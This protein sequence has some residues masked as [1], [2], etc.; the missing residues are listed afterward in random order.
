L[1]RIAPPNPE[2]LVIPA[3]LPPDEAERLAAL[4][5]YQVLDTEPEAG[6]DDL[7]A[8]AAEVAATPIALVS[9]I[10]TDR[11]WFKSRLGLAAC[12]TGRD[13]AFCSHA[14]L[15]DAPM[16]VPETHADARF[17]D[18]P[19]VT[20]EPHIRAYAGIPLRVPA[21]RRVGTLCV[22]DTRPRAF[23]PQQ[24]AS[25]QRLARQVV[26]QLEL[27]RARDEA[28]AAARAK[29]EFL[30]NMSHEIRTPLN[31]VIGMASL[32]VDSNLSA[33]QREMAE[34]LNEC[35][36]HLLA[37]VNDVLD[38]SALEAGRCTLEAQ[39]FDAARLVRRAAAMFE[40]AADAKGVALRI[41]VEPRFA[42][43]R[44][45]DPTR[46][47]QVLLNLIGNAVKFTER[48][49]VDVGMDG[50]ASGLTLRV[51]DTG[52]GMEE[53]TI[54]R[55]FQPFEQGHA[56]IARR[57]GGTGLGLA[58]SARLV[59]LMGGRIEVDSRAGAGSCFTVWLPLPACAPVRAEAPSL[60]DAL[61]GLAASLE[62]GLRVLVAD[63]NAVS[64]LLVRH[65]LERLGCVPQLVTDGIQAVAAWRAGDFD[66]VLMDQHMPGMNGAEAAAVIRADGERGRQATIF[67]L[68]AGTAALERV[69]CLRAGMDDYI[70]K[71]IKPAA[72]AAA[73]RS[74]RRGPA[75]GSLRPAP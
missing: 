46:L 20:G 32:L 70:E 48:G 49:A 5:A 64:A 57:F 73:L 3:L 27:R 37:V 33:A 6:F 52:I 59:A 31:G 40:S 44:R 26:A 67:A 4:R 18:N 25:L 62:P 36:D 1:K 53:A 47:R 14:I 7:T 41:A 38:L 21:G 2:D 28:L 74:V 56:G 8:L 16:I 60:S 23:S 45:G 58:I 54:G 10:D 11:Q 71:P 72:L 43:E 66:V 50:D 42:A 24:I 63:D 17:H 29:S 15:D 51:R 22:I 30:A 69:A 13:I 55:L 61:S 75:A 35:G 12:E 39:P 65:L 9:L 68:S 19:L 34:T